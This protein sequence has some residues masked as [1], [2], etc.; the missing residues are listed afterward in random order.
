MG[1]CLFLKEITI[2]PG[3]LKLGNVFITDHNS[4]WRLLASF[5]LS[6]WNEISSCVLWVL[7]SFWASFDCLSCYFTQM[8]G[9]IAWKRG[10]SGN[11]IFFS[12]SNVCHTMRCLRVILLQFSF[13]RLLCVRVNTIT[14]R[15][16]EGC[17]CVWMYTWLRAA[18]QFTVPQQGPGGDKKKDQ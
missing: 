4:L 8:I 10:I 17:V 3:W 1:E 2:N 18:D 9:S 13:W 7:L 11:A 15:L 12:L 14:G 5:S 16:Q 6:K